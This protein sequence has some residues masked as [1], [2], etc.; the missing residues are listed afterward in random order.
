MLTVADRTQ[1][2]RR[3]RLLFL[4]ALLAAAGTVAVGE[5]RTPSP[6]PTPLEQVPPVQG[7]D[8][9]VGAVKLPSPDAIAAVGGV[10]AATAMRLHS[11]STGS[12]STAALDAGLEIA[13]GSLI[14][15]LVHLPSGTYL[16]AGALQHHALW[17]RD[18]AFAARGLYPLGLQNVARTHLSRVIQAQRPADGLIP[19]VLDSESTRG[20]AWRASLRRWSRLVA[21]GGELQE[22]LVPEY[23]DQHGSVAMDSNALILIAAIDHFDRTQDKA[24]WDS[25]E[26]SLVK[27]LRFYDAY[28]D[29][30]DGLVL[31]GPFSDWQDSVRR[32]GKTF[33][34]NLLVQIATERAARFPA[35]RVDPARTLE[36][37]KRIEAAFFDPGTGLFKSMD[38]GPYVSL[39]GNLLALD[40]GYFAP[41]SE[42][43]QALYAAL[44][45]HALWKSAHDLPGANTVPDYPKSWNSWFAATN[46]LRHAHDRA[47]WSWLMALSAKTAYAMGDVAEGKRLTGQLLALLSR[48]R[49]VVEMYS[50]GDALPPWLS[51]GYEAE[52]P[53][54]WGAGFVV[55]LLQ[56]AKK[57]L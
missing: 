28:R 42:G 26:A 33:Y 30:R 41:A 39:D 34:V 52:R 9:E 24:W 47:F 36:Q 3:T 15:N 14:A 22:P 51:R 35:F 27:A 13:R 57:S 4:G 31:Q 50:Y 43:A 37:R 20:R 46:G 7:P 16:A 12:P 19:R 38:A 44:K 2:R 21:H 5:T 48:D 32:R 1:S 11:S 18:F 53:T 8:L 17:T 6:T 23:K 10:A 40:L 49:S 54:S 29:K 45:R 56:S 55:D 25:V